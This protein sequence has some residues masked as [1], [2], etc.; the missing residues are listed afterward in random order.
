MMLILLLFPAGLWAACDS[1]VNVIEHLDVLSSCAEITYSF[2]KDLNATY[3]G[4]I[5]FKTASGEGSVLDTTFLR[6]AASQWLSYGYGG[7]ILHD[8]KQLTVLRC[9]FRET[10]TDGYGTAISYSRSDGAVN[11][12]DV[13][14]SYCSAIDDGAG[15]IDD[16]AGAISTFARLNFSDGRMRPSDTVGIGGA[17]RFS[18]VAPLP[19]SY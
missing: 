11:L 14:F 9:C 5:Y 4:A 15:T 18:L 7:G 16:H 6:C 8:G 10:K 17:S 12:T 19:N 2:F 13:S 3:G 1:L